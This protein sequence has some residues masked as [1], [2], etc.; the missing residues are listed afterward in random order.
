MLCL[1]RSARDRLRCDQTGST[2]R[3]ARRRAVSAGHRRSPG[4]STVAALRRPPCTAPRR[5]LPD[6]FHAN[7][8]GPS[9]PGP[10][11]PK[12][13]PSLAR[14]TSRD[15]VSGRRG[16]R[17]VG[18]TWLGDRPEIELAAADP[19]MIVV[20]LDSSEHWGELARVR[21]AAGHLARSG[22]SK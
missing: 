8:G 1:A 2:D 18:D 16:C 14:P 4:T 11:R 22:P 21:A 13:G 19:K 10:A 20:G 9:P 7:T 6:L 5:R 3:P 12:P 15:R 17:I